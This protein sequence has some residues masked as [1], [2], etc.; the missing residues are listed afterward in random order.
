MDNLTQHFYTHEHSELLG[1]DYDISNEDYHSSPGI[2]SSMLKACATMSG[3]ELYANSFDP[4]RERSESRAL[5]FGSATHKI[6]LENE[7]FFEEFCIA[8]VVN[9]RTKAGKEELEAFAIENAGREVITP[10]EYEIM[11]GM[12]AAINKHPQACEFLYQD[13]DAE[14]ES[15]QWWV[16]PETNLILRSRSDLRTSDYIVDYKTTVNADR[17]S[18]SRSCANFGYHQQAAHY[19]LGEENIFNAK[20]NRFVFI[21]QAKTKPYDVAVYMLDSEALDLGRRMNNVM[22]KRIARMLESNIWPSHNNGEL[23]ELG[24]PGYYLSKHG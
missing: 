6:I 9:K 19:L 22:R 15:S 13:F 3:A 2:S 18:F 16:D 1:C 4:E 17:E 8:P 14:V 20:H 5:V 24:L 21:V 10:E 23:V 12:H 7:D 11:S